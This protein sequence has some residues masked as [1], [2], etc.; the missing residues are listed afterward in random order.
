MQTILQ[1]LERAGGYRP[2]L[3]LKIPPY[4]ALERWHYGPTRCEPGFDRLWVSLC[5]GY[6][7]TLPTGA[8]QYQAFSQVCAAGI[9]RLPSR[10]G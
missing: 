3:S 6:E 7:S 2:T 8:P 4:M 1:I 10:D 9:A 5:K